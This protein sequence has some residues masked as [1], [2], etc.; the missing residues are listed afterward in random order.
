MSLSNSQVDPGQIPTPYTFADSRASRELQMVDVVLTNIARQYRP[1]GFIADQV[2]PVIPVSADSGKY[3]YFDDAYFFGDDVDPKVGDRA[4]TPE[5][6]LRWSEDTFYCEDYRLK[7]SITKRERKQAHASLRLE[8]SKLSLLQDRLALARERRVAEALR[9]TGAGGQL[10]GGTSAPGVNWDQPTATIEQD[11]KTGALAVYDKTGLTTNVMV[12]DF[13]V[14]YAM[15]LQEDIREIIKFI[16][17]GNAPGNFLELGD[18]VLPDVIHGHKV[19]IAK[20]VLRN[21]AREGGTK[22]LSSVWGDDVRLLYVDSNAGWGTPSTG[23]TFQSMP[24]DVDRWQEN[25]P[26]VEFVRAWDNGD[27]KVCAPDTGYTLTGVLS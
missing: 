12:L 26:P 4:E 8:R 25:D 20:G 6:D 17:T 11:I 14:A 9:H 13:K 15:A 19:V 3:P 24:R 5:I 2:M 16:N 10:T 23:Y 7:F 18:R 1:Q 27:E 21:T 22:S